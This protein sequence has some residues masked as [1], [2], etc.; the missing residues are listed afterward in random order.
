MTEETPYTLRSKHPRKLLGSVSGTPA[1]IY[2]SVQK[3]KQEQVNKEMA[4]KLDRILDHRDLAKERMLRI[5]ESLKQDV[6]NI[7]WLKLQLET[8]R[9]CNDELQK[10]YI[11]ICDI[12]PREQRDEHKQNHFRCEELHNELFVY[13]QTEVAKWNAAEEEKQRGRMSA[14]APVFV[15]Q[16]PV[17]VN[18][19]MPHLQVPLPTFDGSLEN[20]YSFKCMFKTIMNRYPHES[21][22]IKLYH[23]KNS[24]VGSAAG[25]IDQ[26]VIN[27]NDYESAWKMLEETYEDERL[28]IDT[29]I[30]ALLSLPKM[31]SENATELRNLLD[32]CMKHVD[33]LKNRSLP[34]EGLSEMILVN[35]VAKRLDK[36]TRKLWESQIPADELPS[37]TD[38]ID[39]LRDRS[40]ILQKMKSYE[41]YPPAPTKQRG[42]SI[43][44]KPTQA[45]N[46]AQTSTQSNEVCA[47]C[48]G[49]HVIYKCDVFENLT[50]SDRY[51]KV[52]QAGLC[53][54][55]L[56]RGHRTADCNSDRTC[57]TCKRRHHSLLHE[58]KSTTTQPQ[59]SQLAVAVEPVAEEDPENDEPTQGSVNCARTS[60][61]KQV[62]LSTA[63]VLVC[64][65][66]NRRVLCR[67]L[68]DSG[69]DANLISAALAK[70]LNIILQHVNIPIS[71]VNNAA[72]QVKYKLRTKISSRVNSFDAVLD[73]LVVP[74]ITANLPVTKVDTRSWNIPANIALADPSFHAPDEIQMIIG[75]ELFFELLKGGRMKLAGGTP[76]LVETQLGWIVSGW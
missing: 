45:R 29:H 55:C 34:V 67:A 73:F 12:V 59:V 71:G 49:E 16:Q 65:A 62:L 54:N 41:Q 69:S 74:T 22:A 24:L 40:R 70:K 64:D 57:R 31:T 7:H 72:T 35:V 20:W 48:N 9:Q 66:S 8:L 53:F 37:Y 5:R 33:A 38:M 26:D 3:Q 10:T 4:K 30:D 18:N 58:E 39:F 56:R 27:N 1:A 36:E 32:A 2:E 61:T 17:A 42:K 14:L 19:S 43:D 13:I 50:V 60:M 47:C 52:R 11:E 15:P 76:M 46:V 68:L 63:E 25:K 51:T 21:P 6:L 44:Q 23:L 75:A 28:I